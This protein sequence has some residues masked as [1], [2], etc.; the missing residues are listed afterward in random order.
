M[1]F[2]LLLAIGLN[3]SKYID[4]ALLADHPEA[5]TTPAQSVL[6]FKI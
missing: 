2:Y 1:V 6:G 5:V 4:V 3:Y